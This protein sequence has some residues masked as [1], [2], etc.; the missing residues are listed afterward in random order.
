MRFLFLSSWRECMVFAF[1]TIPDIHSSRPKRSQIRNPFTYNK[2]GPK[3]MFISGVERGFACRKGPVANNPSGAAYLR[4]RGHA[5]PKKLS[6]LASYL[7]I[8]RVLV[9]CLEKRLRKT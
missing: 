2:T 7:A 8:W 1:N 6:F 9:T 5:P 3:Y 4:G